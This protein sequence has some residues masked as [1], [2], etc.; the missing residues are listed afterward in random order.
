MSTHQTHL[1]L[2][3]NTKKG[4]ALGD[5][6]TNFVMG[7][8]QKMVQCGN[9]VPFGC[10]YNSNPTHTTACPFLLLPRRTGTDSEIWYKTQATMGGPP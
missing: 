8:Q 2:N 6:Y 10:Y 7:Q 1:F 5:D 4:N 9:E 3:S